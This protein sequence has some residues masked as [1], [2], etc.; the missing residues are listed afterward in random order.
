MQ[1][2]PQWETTLHPVEWILFQKNQTSEKN[3][4]TSFGKREEIGILM[5]Y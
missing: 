1:T 3:Q 2:N 5:H 4:K